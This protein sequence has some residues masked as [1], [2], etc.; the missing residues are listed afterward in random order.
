VL[1]KKLKKDVQKVKKGL[2]DVTSEQCK[3]YLSE[4]KITVAGIE[5]VEG[6]LVVKRAL[7]QDEESKDQETNTDDDVLTILDVA[8]YPE[9]AEEGLAREIINRVQ[10]LRKKANLKPTDDVKMEYKVQEDPD[11]VG[12]ESVFHK[13]SSFIEKAL[14]RPVDKHVVTEVEGP[15][16]N[17]VKDDIIVEEVQEVQKATF[18]LRLLKL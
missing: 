7:K 9:L 4:R 17:G 15:V 8:I 11:N 3:A 2:P 10:Q 16:V 5:L 12:I 1:G 13:Q 14:R 18:L 6:D